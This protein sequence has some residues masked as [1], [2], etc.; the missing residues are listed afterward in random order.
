M[1]DIGGELER[2]LRPKSVES[3][4]SANGD[5]WGT[6]ERWVV[7]SVGQELIP[8]IRQQ[9]AA[10]EE[11]LKPAPRGRTLTR[12]LVLLRHYNTKVNEPEIEEMIANDWAEDLEE[13]PA[14]AVDDAARK[15]RRTQKWRPSI[16]EIR[17][18]CHRAV[19]RERRLKERLEAILKRAANS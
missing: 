17:E 9:L 14:W 6:R 8:E 11:V 4:F 7:P 10:L 5:F 1:L 2:L 16:Q 3:V 19:A 13:F 15:W 18:L 12:I